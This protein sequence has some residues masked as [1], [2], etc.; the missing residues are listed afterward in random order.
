MEIFLA[1]NKRDNLPDLCKDYF[2]EEHV[3]VITRN[4]ALSLNEIGV[5][6]TGI[7]AVSTTFDFLYA[8]L[9]EAYNQKKADEKNT[10]DEE[11][12]GDKLELQPPNGQRLVITKNGD[13][14]LENYSI[15]EVIHFFNSITGERYDN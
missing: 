2:G 10:N 13:I 8:V 1:C 11:N 15:K 14:C 7:G 6:L 5:L 12:T 4:G 9:S 3:E